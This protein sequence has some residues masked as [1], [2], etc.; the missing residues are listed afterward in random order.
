MSKTLVVT[1][2]GLEDGTA[3]LVGCTREELAEDIVQDGVDG[4]P[5]VRFGQ[6]DADETFEAVGR[7]F[8]KALEA[9]G[10][11]VVDEVV[12]GK[13]IITDSFPEQGYD[14]GE[15]VAVEFKEQYPLAEEYEPTLAQGECVAVYIKR[16]EKTDE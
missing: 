2:Q 15:F 10:I 11:V 12:E 5:P 8:R 16:K 13:V 3:V 1:P 7:G 14:G 9:A 6:K 4:C